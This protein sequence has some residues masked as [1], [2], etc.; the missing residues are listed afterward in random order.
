MTAAIGPMDPCA[1]TVDIDV[2][3]GK[4]TV[5]G[6]LDMRTAPLLVDTVSALL[7]LHDGDLVLDLAA[8][9]FLDAAGMSGLVQLG[10]KLRLSRRR[11][12]MVAVPERVNRLLVLA[13]LG[14]LAGGPSPAVTARGRCDWATGIPGVLWE[15]VS[16]RPWGAH[17]AAAHSA[18]SG[19]PHR[20]GDCRHIFAR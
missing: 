1:M 12:I 10:N 20:A 5:S 2:G 13:G 16:P 4:A 19:S 6:C 8:L 11:M 14:Y 17:R 15:L 7:R 18:P 9:R 3:A